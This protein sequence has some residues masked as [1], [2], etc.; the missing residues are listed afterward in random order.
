M[1]TGDPSSAARKAAARAML[2][3]LPPVT[4]SAAELPGVEPLGRGLRREDAAPDLGPLGGV[5][6]RELDDEAQPAQEGRV[7]RV[8]EVGGQDRQAPVGLHALEQVA[9]LDVGVAVVAV[10]DLA[11]LAEQGVG[12][13]EEE[14][15]AA[16]L[17]GVEDAAQVLLGLADV[18]ADH[19]GE[20][21]AVEVEPQLARPAPR[22]PSSCPCRS[23]PRRAR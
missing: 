12:L 16:L 9:D 13:V 20:V 23:A 17:G 5:R 22:R 15:G 6:E 10:L 14:D 3:M 7:E 11:A 2:R 8:L 19:R 4:F 18:L 1:R 21:D